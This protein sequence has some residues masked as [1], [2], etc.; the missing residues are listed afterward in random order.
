M[1]I[2]TN[3]QIDRGLTMHTNL[4]FFPPMKSQPASQRMKSQWKEN[5]TTQPNKNNFYYCLYKQKI[6]INKNSRILFLRKEIIFLECFI[7]WYWFLFSRN[8]YKLCL[9][10]L[11]VVVKVKSNSKFQRKFVVF[12]PNFLNKNKETFYL[13]VVVS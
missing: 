6:F 9:G 10:Y 2:K 11:M 7:F 4:S 1:Q 12:Y 5:E 3:V 13:V 8:I